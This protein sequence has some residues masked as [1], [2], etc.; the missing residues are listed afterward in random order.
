MRVRVVNANGAEAF[1]R[2]AVVK[3][4]S[5][6][7]FEQPKFKDKRISVVSKRDRAVTLEWKP[8]QAG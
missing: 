3:T 2:H 1:Y 4:P 5:V 7:Y 6:T 8:A